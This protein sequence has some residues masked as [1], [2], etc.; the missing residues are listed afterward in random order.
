[1]HSQILLSVGL[2]DGIP[3]AVTSLNRIQISVR[4]GYYIGL[5]GSD[6]KVVWDAKG[7]RLQV[8]WGHTSVEKKPLRPAL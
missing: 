6:Q 8:P 7:I 5:S 2:Q 3:D 1:M 4:L